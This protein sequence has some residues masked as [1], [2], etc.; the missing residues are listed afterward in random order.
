[1]HSKLDAADAVCALLHSCCRCCDTA[2][3]PPRIHRM[4]RSSRRPH[5][6]TTNTTCAGGETLGVQKKKKKKSKKRDE[7]DAAAAAAAGE[8][9]EEQQLAAAGE[10]QEAGPSGAKK[11]TTGAITTKGTTYEQEFDLEMA[12]LKV[13]G[14]WRASR[15]VWGVE[16]R[17]LLLA[18]MAWHDAGSFAARLAVVVEGRWLHAAR[19]PHLTTT[20]PST[21]HLTAPQRTKPHKPLTARSKARCGRRRG[22]PPTAPRPRSST[23]TTKRS[24]ARRP[25]SGWTCGEGHAV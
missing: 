14:G 5:Q 1:V 7:G 19:L 11:P 25:A 23:A 20:H 21:P 6:N 22:A 9:G 4:C 3:L 13:G 10:Q 24:R 15:A 2:P 12:R 8:G 17:V 18:C 16:G